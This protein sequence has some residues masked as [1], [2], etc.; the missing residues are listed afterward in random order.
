MSMYVIQFFE[1]ER[2]TMLVTTVDKLFTVNEV[3]Q[4]SAHYISVI[5][6][7][8]SQPPQYTPVFLI[9]EIIEHVRMVVAMLLCQ[10]SF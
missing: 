6:I 9:E 8:F 7:L 10:A 2:M 4:Q 3:V 1:A 5:Q